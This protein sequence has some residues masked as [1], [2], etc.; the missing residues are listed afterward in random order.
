M[1]PFVGFFKIGLPETPGFGQVFVLIVSLISGLFLPQ[2][3]GI[4]PK[5]G[6]TRLLWSNSHWISLENIRNSTTIGMPSIYRWFSPSK[7]HKKWMNFPGNSRW[8][9]QSEYEGDEIS[10]KTIFKPYLHRFTYMFISYIF[11]HCHVFNL[12]LFNLWWFLSVFSCVD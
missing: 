10:N 9:I 5:S 1:D 12:V 3:L 2:T 4:A 11:Q 8:F 7:L 6:K